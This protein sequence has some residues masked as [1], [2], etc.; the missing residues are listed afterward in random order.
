MGTVC[1]VRQTN[2]VEKG[3]AMAGIAVEQACRFRMRNGYGICARS[4]G[5]LDQ[6]AERMGNE[7][8]DIMNPL[9]GGHPGQSVLS[10]VQSE[11]DVFVALCTMRTE[12]HGRLAIFTHSYLL[13]AAEYRLLME[14][15]PE[16][17]LFAPLDKMYTSL[18]G[19]AALPQ[20]ELVLDHPGPGLEALREK[21]HLGD[22]QYALL[23]W[24][25]YDA[26]CRQ[27]SLCLSFSS[28][29][30]DRMKEIRELCYCV[31][32]GLLPSMR[33]RVSFASSCDMRRQ[34]CMEEPQSGY[35]GGPGIR[36][37]LDGEGSDYRLEELDE[38][39][40]KFVLHLAQAPA[41]HREALLRGLDQWLGN[42]LM[43]G[44]SCPLELIVTAYFLSGGETIGDATAR[45]LLA[46]LTRAA[47]KVQFQE[48]SL[49]RVLAKL[50]QSLECFPLRGGEML[51][52]RAQQGKLPFD[53]VLCLMHC[54]TEPE[55]AQLLEQLLNRARSS[56]TDQMVQQLL[57]DLPPDSSVLEEGLRAQ[58][59]QWLF[60]NPTE[61]GI[62]Y[63]VS[64]LKRQSAEQCRQIIEQ[65]L[66]AAGPEPLKLALPQLLYV[67]FHT[68]VERFVEMEP[69]QICRYGLSGPARDRW[70]RWA[71]GGT[72]PE[73]LLQE[74]ARYCVETQY[75]C[76]G[77]E[78]E[79]AQALLLCCR[80]FPHW[81]KNLLKVVREA[82][83][84]LNDEVILQGFLS[85]VSSREKLVQLCAGELSDAELAEGSSSASRA[86][87]LFVQFFRQ[88]KRGL[89]SRSLRNQLEQEA[90]Q[91]AQ[92]H[93]APQVQTGIL[94]Q[95]AQW[96][97]KQCSGGEW[98]TEAAAWLTLVQQLKLLSLC[99]TPE[100]Q[101]LCSIRQLEQGEGGQAF[102]ALIR[103]KG[104]LSEEKKRELFDSL[105]QL[106]ARMGKK[107]IFSWELP[108][109]YSCQDACQEDKNHLDAQKLYDLLK[110]QETG[111][112]FAWPAEVERADLPAW[113]DQ[114]QR[115][116]LGK[117]LKRL[118]GRE[119]G[120]QVQ[121]LVRVLLEK[122]TAGKAKANAHVSAD[123][124][125]GIT[126]VFKSWFGHK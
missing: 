60:S 114:E 65:M 119:A 94:E 8:N 104:G 125:N 81:G 22:A 20:A 67:A 111:Q 123:H 68:G 55:K 107:G 112:S 99:K 4:A 31:L 48:N 44:Q 78:K 28:V 110:R 61:N 24:S 35:V 6:S 19:G 79:G 102:S 38:V 45:S 36:F 93:L 29:R 85:N 47:E 17:L 91:L 7:F 108:F 57:V 83:P 117:E 51:L 122:E 118:A 89:D 18:P 59:L 77:R 98:V 80:E 15:N 126:S 53:Q 16:K 86:R 82:F 69:E 109:L 49:D 71:E 121:D 90:L 124:E 97:L 100:Y 9:F 14:E 70:D 72:L 27:S 25:A 52:E 12:A 3:E 63:A 32:M 34:I 95:E 40:R 42:L 26:I 43:P 66:T 116:L 87:Q 74:S 115:R 58:I 105:P 13:P 75:A 41:E 120:Q 23:L 101:L 2:M 92:T 5:F 21:Y 113:V 76:L 84:K 46:S 33:G 39:E 103:G 88:E 50:M 106:M 73:P 11:E 64:L 30:P 56:A 37:C 10:C 62:Q 1:P 96:A 54:C